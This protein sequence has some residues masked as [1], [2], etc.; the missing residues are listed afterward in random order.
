MLVIIYAKKATALLVVG[1]G[2]PN[3]LKGKAPKRLFLQLKK[4]QPF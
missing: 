3:S 2:L 1:I 4:H